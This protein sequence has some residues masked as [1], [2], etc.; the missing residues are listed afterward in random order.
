MGV[1]VT[2]PVFNFEPKYKVNMLTRE[3][4]T[5]GWVK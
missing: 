2:R 3:E 5:A 4:Q 1:E